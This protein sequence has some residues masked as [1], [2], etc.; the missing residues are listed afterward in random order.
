MV[1]RSRDH[2]RRSPANNRIMARARKGATGPLARVAAAPKKYRSKSQDFLPVSYQAYQP[3]IP[4]QSGAASCMSVEAP[5]EKLKIATGD[6]VMSAAS[7]CPPGLNRRVCRKISTISAKA[8]D[9]E[10]SL[11]DQS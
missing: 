1:L 11:A 3:S 10:G 5:R 8:P 4:I 7:R 6:M 2:S 9:E